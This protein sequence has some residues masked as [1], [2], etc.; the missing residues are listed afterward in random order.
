[1]D[2]HGLIDI[3][4]S[5]PQYTWSN[6]RSDMALIRERLDRAMATQEWRLLFPD[7]SLQ[8]LASSASDH[9]PLLLH[10]INNQKHASSFKFEEFW[11]HEPLS[12]NIIREAWNKAFQGNPAYILCQKIKSTKEALKFWNRNHFGRIQDNI[13]KLEI[14]LI[15]IQ[16]KPIGEYN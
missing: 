4:Y 1:M 7:A 3:G 16:S 12:H 15:D 11:I 9:H 13:Q 10:T 8:H 5:G 6:N 14:D 2:R